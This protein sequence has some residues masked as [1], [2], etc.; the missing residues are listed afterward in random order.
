MGRIAAAGDRV[1]LTSDNPRTEAP[2]TILDEIEPG[3]REAGLARTPLAELGRNGKGYAREVDRHAAIA[4][5]VAQATAGDILLV[6]GKGHEDYQI[7]GREK[8]HFDDREEVRK[9][10]ALPRG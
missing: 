8:R 9:A 6:A 1:V 10:A 3:L 5:A 4:A 2:E 7:V